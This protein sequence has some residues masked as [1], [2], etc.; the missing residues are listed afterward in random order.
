MLG[1]QILICRCVAIEAPSK[2]NAQTC[3]DRRPRLSENEGCLLSKCRASFPHDI[4][5][6][7]LGPSGTPVPTDLWVIFCEVPL[8][9]HAD[10]SQFGGGR[11]VNHPYR[12]VVKYFGPTQNTDKSQ[13]VL[14]AI[15]D[16]L[17]ILEILKQFEKSKMSMFLYYFFA[18]CTNVYCNRGGGVI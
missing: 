18:F 9:K 4:Y 8:S 14:R 16:H 6:F 1:V 13:F 3:R 10:K 7:V 15:R 5:P 12:R 2:I 17:F 11:F